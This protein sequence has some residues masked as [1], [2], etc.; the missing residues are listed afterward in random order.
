[1]HVLLRFHTVDVFTRFRFGGNPLAV[2][3]DADDLTTEQ[4]QK[5]AREFNYSESSFV[6]RP[7]DPSHTAHVRIFTPTVE[8]P[9]AGHPNVG[10]AFV[11]ASAGIG[12]QADEFIFEETAGLVR[13][14]VL[15]DGNRIDQIRL[16][17]PQRLR[18]G[19]A[20]DAATIA[21]CLSLTT[22]DIVCER[23][24]P[25]VASV[26]LPF[27]IVEIADRRAL[28]RAKANIPRF[29]EILPSD[30]VD[31][32][33][34]YCRELDERDGT[35]DFTARMFAPFDNVPE[36]PA[37]GSAAAA[38]CA[39]MVSLEGQR[40]QRFEIAQGIDMGR[41]SL[42]SIEVTP[43]AVLIGGACIPV[44]SGELEV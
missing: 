6:L 21:D 33:Y 23:H 24:P 40:S 18:I 34:L 13:A 30:G 38:A 32:I 27:I 11:L 25:R 29:H 4:M 22:A 35:V 14:R 41:P 39:L 43:E 17:A 44:M 3:L 31:A 28:A 42:I 5:I 36:D 12:K 9:F 8:V 7:S 15:R 2:V 20:F 10:T 1:M 19:R 16:A 37:T 26:G